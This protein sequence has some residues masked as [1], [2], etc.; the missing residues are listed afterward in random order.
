[1]IK[2]KTI[3]MCCIRR[4]DKPEELL[5][6]EDKVIVFDWKEDAEDFMDRYPEAFHGNYNKENVEIVDINVIEG[7]DNFML[8]YYDPDE[9]KMSYLEPKD[10]DKSK[11]EI[12]E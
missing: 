5:L 2:I 4:K 9:D 6:F 1:M 11:E 12:K 3:E 7:F 10:K 8:A